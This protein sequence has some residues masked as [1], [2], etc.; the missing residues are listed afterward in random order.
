MDTPR[1]TRFHSAAV[2]PWMALALAL[3]LAGILVG[4]WQWRRSRM[5]PVVEEPDPRLI[6]PT[7]YRN[8]HPDVHY[9]GDAACVGC[10]R[11]IA[12]SYAR[13]P[14]GRSLAPLA[15]AAP[16][17]RLDGNASNPFEAFGLLHRVERRDQRMIHSERRLSAD[18]QPLATSEVEIDFIL[19]SGARG[20]SYLINNGGRLFQ[21]SASWYVSNQK[22]A[23][24]PGYESHD[25]HFDRPVTPECLSCHANRVNAVQHSVNAYRTPIFEG[26]AIGCERCHGPGELHVATSD[27]LD[28]VNPRNLAS[29]LRDSVCEQCHL[30]GE[31]RILRHGRQLEDF[32]PGLPLHLFWAVFV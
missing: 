9:V 20:R 14:M 30:S 15:E 13:H 24:P 32:R 29:S 16:V 31:G 22:W 2:R 19:G 7:P 25:R 17:E 4:A 5:Q 11:D 10:H 6:F 12:Q 1:P 3:G 21:S 8:V 18:G 27:K 26:Y 23:L 28:I